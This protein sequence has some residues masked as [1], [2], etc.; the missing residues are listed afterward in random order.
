MSANPLAHSRTQIDPR[1]PQVSEV[2]PAC[3]GDIPTQETL[4]AAALLRELVP[5]LAVRVV[6]VV[7]LAR[8]FPPDR[9]PHGMPDDEYIE[10]F[11]RFRPVI[12]AFHGYPWLIHFMTTAPFQM[13]AMNGI[14]RYHLALAALEQLP[15]VGDRIAHL[16]ER[17]L[18]LLDQAHTYACRTGEDPPE[19]S[20]W[21]WAARTNI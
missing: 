12:F 10:I 5:D 17:L 18:T 9:H 11:T 7:D 4:A 20:E 16:R 21:S 6:N 14:D 2:V 15:R 19:I 1:L 3:A 13:C 8:L